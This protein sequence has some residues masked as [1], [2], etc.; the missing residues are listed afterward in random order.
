MWQ[1]KNTR[2]ITAAL[3]ALLV[4]VVL[5]VAPGLLRSHS[6]PHVDHGHA[7]S[8]P[9][10]PRATNTSVPTFPLANNSSNMQIGTGYV[11]GTP[12]QITGQTSDFRSSDPYAVL[13]NI[14]PNTLGVS[15]INFELIRRNANNTDSLLL[16]R[17]ESVQSNWA[18]VL[19]HDA[20]MSKLMGTE[21]PGQYEIRITDSAGYFGYVD[22][23]YH[24]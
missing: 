15:Q 7:T 20:S 18:T 21:P 2:A 19:W 1:D 16:S 3:A 22:F 23:N 6:T 14:S 8:T 13:L 5:F 11:D 4:I 24:G 9:S 10:K 12:Q 17:A